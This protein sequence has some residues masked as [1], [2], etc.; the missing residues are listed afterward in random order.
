MF[1]ALNARP[2]LDPAIES[3]RSGYAIRSKT[4]SVDDSRL[5]HRLL[6]SICGVVRIVG[7]AACL[8]KFA[9]ILYFLVL[10]VLPT[11]QVSAGFIL[12]DFNTGLVTNNPLA[13]FRFVNDSLGDRP[14]LDFGLSVTQTSPAEAILYYDTPGGYDYGALNRFEL[15]DVLFLSFDFPETELN[16]VVKA[17]GITLATGQVFDVNGFPIIDEDG[18]PLLEFNLA[19]ELGVAELL[20]FHFSTNGTEDFSFNST[21]LWG[22]NSIQAIPEPTSILLVSAAFACGSGHYQIR[23]RRKPKA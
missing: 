18:F 21:G 7:G 10:I 2:A 13:D 4:Q 6:G 15:R 22:S 23:K 17:D 1:E 16:A 3:C 8:P 12:D 5:V 9:I 11:E 14:Y 20:S 19:N